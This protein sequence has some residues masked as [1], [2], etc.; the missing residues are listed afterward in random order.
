MV[1]IAGLRDTPPPS[2]R[3][4]SQML[5]YPKAKSVVTLG[6]LRYCL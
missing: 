3:D 2:Q 4:E 1:E 5:L 6:A